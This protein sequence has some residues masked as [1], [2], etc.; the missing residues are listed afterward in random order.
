MWSP[1]IEAYAP[2]VWGRFNVP[3]FSQQDIKGGFHLKIDFYSEWA[4]GTDIN[5]TSSDHFYNRTDIFNFPFS[6]QWHIQSISA[7]SYHVTAQ[8]FCA[9]CR[10]HKRAVLLRLVDQ[11][12]V[13][14]RVLN[15]KRKHIWDTSIK[16]D[17]QK[18]L[19]FTYTYYRIIYCSLWVKVQCRY[20]CPNS[21]L[22]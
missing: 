19:L 8:G 3:Y 6:P 16:S 2:C 14:V 22:L 11:S 15:E 18:S 9:T 20:S 1:F 4:Y 13:I 7:V 17:K 10:T 21:L 5:S 12:D